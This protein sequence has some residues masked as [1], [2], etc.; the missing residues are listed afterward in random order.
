MVIGIF[1][2]ETITKTTIIN[3][4]KMTSFLEQ[5]I[6]SAMKNGASSKIQHQR[7]RQTKLKIGCLNI[8]LIS[9]QEKNGHQIHSI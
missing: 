9:S 5:A 6:F 7:I 3:I 8:A 1:F 4:F 2:I